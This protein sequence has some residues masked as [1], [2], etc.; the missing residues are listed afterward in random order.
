MATS[1][2]MDPGLSPEAPCP[3]HLRVDQ[4]VRSLL[5]ATAHE[6]GEREPS[7]HRAQGPVRACQASSSS[8]SRDR[9]IE[10]PRC[11]RTSVKCSK[12]LGARASAL[13]TSLPRLRSAQFERSS[14][15]LR[16]HPVVPDLAERAGRFHGRRVQHQRVHVAGCERPEPARAG[17]Y[18][19]GA[20]LD[21]LSG[22]RRRPVDDRELSGQPRGA[23][24]S[25]GGGRLSRAGD[26]VHER[27]EPQRTD[28]RGETGR[29]AGAI[30]PCGT[31]E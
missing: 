31:W 5:C 21:R 27:P 20:A 28:P 22:E 26:P 24:R 13:C 12:P 23:R 7:E 15:L 1:L 6:R 19:L 8:K 14:A 2:L 9:S 17:R 25:A 30:A 3:S 16:V 11:S 18:R 29:R 10:K 4:G